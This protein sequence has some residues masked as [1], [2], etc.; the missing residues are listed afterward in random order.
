MNQR[1]TSE[2]PQSQ[3]SIFSQTKNSNFLNQELKFFIEDLQQK[4][5][6]SGL[7]VD[8]LIPLETKKDKHIF[9]YLQRQKEEPSTRPQ[10]RIDSSTMRSSFYST[11]GVSEQSDQLEVNLDRETQIQQKVVNKLNISNILE[12]STQDKQIVDQIKRFMQQ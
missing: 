12:L 2:K 9:N 7:D 10:S 1:K 11:G 8:A 4:A 5:L 6:K 3:E